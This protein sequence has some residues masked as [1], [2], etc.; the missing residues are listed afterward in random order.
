MGPLLHPP[1]LRR[2]KIGPSRRAPPFES[3]KVPGR[4]ILTPTCLTDTLGATTKM[5]LARKI[6]HRRTSYIVL[7][8]FAGSLKTG[9][10]LQTDAQESSRE[11]SRTVPIILS[12]L[13][14][15]L[16]IRTTVRH[17]I[18]KNYLPTRI[19]E[20]SWRAFYPTAAWCMTY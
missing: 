12:A 16:S 15:P 4:R 1:G 3:F 7:Q 17:K 13:V 14:R 8:H 9:S 11:Q 18:K 6:Q 20:G 10:K 19:V 5:Q 2:F